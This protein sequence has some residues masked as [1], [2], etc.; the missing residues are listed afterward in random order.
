MLLLFLGGLLD[1][2]Y[3]GSTTAP[4]RHHRLFADA[5]DSI[6]R[7]RIDPQPLR[8]HVEQAPGV[9]DVNGLGITLVG[10]TLRVGAPS[11]TPP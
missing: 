10:T 2:L 7:W 1:G 6:I 8:A 3:L 4:R 11:P 5:N 9:T